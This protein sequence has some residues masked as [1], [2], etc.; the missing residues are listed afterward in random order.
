[1][2]KLYIVRLHAED[3]AARLALIKELKD[4]SNKVRRA[5]I[6]LKADADGPHW[7][8]QD[9]AD[10]FLC[11]RQTVENVRKRL[12]TEGFDI[13]VGGKKREVPD[14]L[15]RLD[16]HQEAQVIALRL[17]DPPKGRNG[18]SVFGWCI[19]LRKQVFNTI[20][21]AHNLLLQIELR[22]F[23]AFSL[24]CRTKNINPSRR[25]CGCVPGGQPLLNAVRLPAT[26]RLP[27]GS[28]FHRPLLFPAKRNRQDTP[29]T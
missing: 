17:S 6:L 28:M 7:T 9:I 24:R 12:V 16:G 15:K 1:M 22:S 3:R 8:D 29:A 26:G 25:N 21:V 14:S 4:S 19:F 23:S 2:Q 13:A 27:S 20:F 5:N 10:A 18:Y 11:T